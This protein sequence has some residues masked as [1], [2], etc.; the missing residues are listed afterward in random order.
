MNQQEALVIKQNHSQFIDLLYLL[1]Q[2]EVV[3]INLDESDLTAFAEM[4]AD[5]LAN[6]KLWIAEHGRIFNLGS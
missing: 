4:Y 6:P 2:F 5:F 3:E 1:I